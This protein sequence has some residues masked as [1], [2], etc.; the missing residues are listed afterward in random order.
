MSERKN[1][2]LRPQNQRICFRAFVPGQLPAVAT[3]QLVAGEL[4][5]PIL[6]LSLATDGQR[7]GLRLGPPGAVITS[8]ESL[9]PGDRLGLELV[10]PTLPRLTADATFLRWEEN[11]RRP[12]LRYRLHDRRG[13]E[14]LRHFWAECQRHY[15][16]PV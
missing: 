10:L 8:L 3:L 11:P 1:K 15:L 12:V 9:R 2:N 5:L 14:P 13:E 7:G 16:K 6:E 4:R